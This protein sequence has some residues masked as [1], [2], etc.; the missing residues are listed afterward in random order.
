MVCSQNI[1]GYMLT[2]FVYIYLLL[3]C[4]SK[5]RGFLGAHMPAYGHPDSTGNWDHCRENYVKDEMRWGSNNTY[6]WMQAYGHPDSACTI[7]QHKFLFCMYQQ[8]FL[9]IWH[10]LFSPCWFN[11]F[12]FKFVSLSLDVDGLTS[13][14][15]MGSNPYNL[16]FTTDFN[17]LNSCCCP[18][19]EG[20]CFWLA[21]YV[22]DVARESFIQDIHLQWTCNVP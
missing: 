5:C 8:T 19:N 6:W 10:F 14:P 15:C 9:I 11:L 16:A 13:F 22:L 18:N 21:T 1:C 7:S 4:G 2:S 3:S 17:L 20:H 12:L